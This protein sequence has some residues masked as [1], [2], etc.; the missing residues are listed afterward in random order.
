M[1]IF[2]VQLFFVFNSGELWH[3]YERVNTN[4]VSSVHVYAHF[5]PGLFSEDARSFVSTLYTLCVHGVWVERVSVWLLTCSGTESDTGSTGGHWINQHFS[6]FVLRLWSSLK[7]Q[8]QKKLLVFL[9]PILDNIFQS[10]SFR[11]VYFFSSS[12]LLCLSPSQPSR[13]DPVSPQRIICSSLFVEYLS[14]KQHTHKESSLER[15]Q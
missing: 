9:L 3:A 12:C 8:W 10:I 14:P 2:Y 7:H 1:H 11:P 4:Y 6:R 5:P 13:K 15:K